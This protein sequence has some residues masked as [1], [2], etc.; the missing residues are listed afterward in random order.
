MDVIAKARELGQLIAESPEMNRLS[1]AEES[2]ERDD[3]AKRLLE[4]YKLL[5]IELVRATKEGRDKDIVDSIKQRLMDK[6][7]EVNEYE[8]TKNYLESKSDF[9]KMM[10]DINN[11]IIHTITGEEPCSPNKCGSCGG[12]CK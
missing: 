6:Q 7:K 5:Q 12:G 1:R 4:D 3:T 2:I 9:D 10:K 11:V 8:V